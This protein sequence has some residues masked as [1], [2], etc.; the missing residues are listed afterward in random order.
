M[1]YHADV[2]N[3]PNAKPAARH[4]TVIPTHTPA[5]ACGGAGHGRGGVTP[6]LGAPGSGPLRAGEGALGGVR[7]PRVEPPA[8]EPNYAD[9]LVAPSI[10]S[11]TLSDASRSDLVERW[12]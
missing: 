6:T 4:L 3:T 2:V 11:D 12:A 8:P 7:V 10:A 5:G 9:F 1:I